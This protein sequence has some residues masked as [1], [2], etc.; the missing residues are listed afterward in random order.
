MKDI[1]G[2]EEIATTQIICIIRHNKNCEKP[3]VYN[4]IFKERNLKDFK[5]N[6]EMIKYNFNKDESNEL[7][8]GTESIKTIIKNK[9]NYIKNRN[10]HFN[11]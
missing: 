5:D 7:T 9:N 11:Y 4:V 1:K 10:I 8:K 2:D 3:K 6:N